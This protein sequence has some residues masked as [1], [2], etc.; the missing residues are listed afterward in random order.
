MRKISTTLALFGALSVVFGL[1][2]P[3]GF[4]TAHADDQFDPTVDYRSLKE[5]FAAEDAGASYGDKRLYIR[6]PDGT[7]K[8][9]RPIRRRNF[10][11]SAKTRK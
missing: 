2:T 10:S 6:M 8:R 7:V 5:E 11:T 9:R 1:G 4:S 3:G